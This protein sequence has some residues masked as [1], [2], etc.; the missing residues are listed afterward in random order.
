MNETKR[1]ER[2]R[3]G[4]TKQ[5]SRKESKRETFNFVLLLLIC[6]VQKFKSALISSPRK[7]D[8]T[9]QSRLLG[10][11]RFAGTLKFCPQPAT[12]TIFLAGS[13]V[14]HDFRL[15]PK[16]EWGKRKTYVHCDNCIGILDSSTKSCYLLTK[17]HNWIEFLL[18]CG[19]VLLECFL[20][21]F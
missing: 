1:K 21:V 13:Q 10:W 20:C 9:I 16:K 18:S 15:K 5:E 4:R 8:A 14:M 6:I 7:T 17:T 19:H 2:M 3:W 11:G 12:F